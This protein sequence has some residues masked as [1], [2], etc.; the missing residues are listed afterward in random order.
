MIL[1]RFIPFLIAFAISPL[2]V[3]AQVLDDL[4]EYGN[5]AEANAE[6]GAGMARGTTYDA[7]TDVYTITAGG[8]DFW[9]PTDHGSAIFDADGSTVDGN[10]SAVVKVSI[11]LPGEVMPGEW[12]RSG[13]MARTDPA[14]PASAYFA[15][16]QKFNGGKQHIL[17]ARDAAGGDT[18]RPSNGAT[19]TLVTRSRP[20]SRCRS[21]LVGVAS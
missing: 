13:I 4:F 8:T 1:R 11:G 21:G 2:A 12:G 18:G 20:R 17:Q 14:D 6:S 15:S 19:T 5:A 9:S 7:A 16:T 3:N 10:F